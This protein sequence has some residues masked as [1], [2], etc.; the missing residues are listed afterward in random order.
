MASVQVKVIESRRR[1]GNEGDL[2]DLDSHV[3]ETYAALGIVEIVD[4]KPKAKASKKSEVP[5]TPSNEVQK[6]ELN[7]G[8]DPSSSGSEN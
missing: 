8:G 3:A 5:T 6:D 1:L 7:S 2:R 4:G